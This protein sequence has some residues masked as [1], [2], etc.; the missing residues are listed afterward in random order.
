[1]TGWLV[2]G[3]FALLGGALLL[4]IRFPRRLWTLPTMAVMLAAAGYAWQGRPGLA[5][6][7]AQGAT[8]ARPLDQDV[9]AVREAMFGRFNFDFSYFM[10]ADGMIRA[11]APRHAAAVMLGAVR[12]APN[13]VG[14][15]SW[16]GVALAEQ[17]GDQL[18]PAARFAFDKAAKLGPSHPGPPFFLGIALA[19]SGD[20]SAARNAWGEALQRVPK[21]ASYR[22][23]M[24]K[25]MLTLDPSLA[26]AAA[27]A[28][29]AENAGRAR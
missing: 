27:T 2:F 28:A 4:L 15:W 11:G 18:S 3:G 12:K 23:D 7:P 25:A 6:Q 17:D 14:L 16:L 1:M 8:N 24:V 26:E 13:D 5:G 10:A 22:D 9:I 20:I 19:R 29:S 21:D